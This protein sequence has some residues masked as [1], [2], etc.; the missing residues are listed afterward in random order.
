MIIWPLNLMFDQPL[1]IFNLN[2]GIDFRDQFLLKY[3]LEFE[4]LVSLESSSC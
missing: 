3:K 2:L 4:T 1:F